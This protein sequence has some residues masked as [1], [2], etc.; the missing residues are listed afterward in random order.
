MSVDEEHWGK[1]GK[2]LE[3]ALKPIKV[4]HFCSCGEFFEEVEHYTFQPTGIAGWYWNCEECGSTLYKP[5]TEYLER[6][7]AAQGRSG[8]GTAKAK[9]KTTKNKATKKKKAVSV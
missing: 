2:T 1:L 5:T 9:K 6:R 4:D 3:K 7:K 8:P